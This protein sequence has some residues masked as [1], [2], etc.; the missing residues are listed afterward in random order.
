[1]KKNK[2]IKIIAIIILVIVILIGIVSGIIYFYI[3]N[4]LNKIN[5]VDVDL[6]NI[7]INE[8]VKE[9]LTGYRNIALFGIDTRSDDYGLGNRSDCIIIASINNDTKEVKLTS[10]YRDSYLEIPNRGL[11]KVTHAYSFGGA[12]LALSTLNSNLDLNMTEFITVNFDAVAEIVNSLG[13]V[14]IDITPEEVGYFK[15]YTYATAQSTGIASSVITEPG[16][17]NL[18]GVQAVAYSRIRYTAGGDYKRTERMRTVL[19]A[20]V[21]KAKTKNISELNKLMDTLL[22]RIYTN[23]DKSEILSLL[24]EAMSYSIT[25]SI[26]WPYEVDGG[27]ISGIWYGVPSNLE[28]NVSRLHQELFP[29]ENYE[30][31]QKVKDISQKIINKTGRK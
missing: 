23:I 12:E 22:P 2:V 1:M 4:K 26:G 21:E 28:N 8:E 29:N 27:K 17:H 30:P 15:S 31:S 25:D 24:P 6:N 13:G 14:E 5:K 11:D 18:N 19:T 20:I 9:K 10:V 3:N 7:T 16:K